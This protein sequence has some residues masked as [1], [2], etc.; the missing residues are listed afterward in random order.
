MD[1]ER[2]KSGTGSFVSEQRKAKIA[3]KAY[4]NRNNRNIAEK[5]EPSNEVS[6]NLGFCVLVRKLWLF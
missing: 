3:G 5:Q 1:Q 2:R 6:C 4:V